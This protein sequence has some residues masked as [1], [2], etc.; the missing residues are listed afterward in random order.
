[1]FP[2]IVIRYVL[3]SMAYESTEARQK[4]PRLLQ[5]VELHPGSDVEAFK[6]KVTVNLPI[7]QWYSVHFA[8]SGTIF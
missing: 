5:L 6:R 1:M 2:G 4:F 7:V 8:S 3:K